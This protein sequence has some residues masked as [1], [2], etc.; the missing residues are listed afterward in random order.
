[1]SFCAGLGD[2]G[3]LCVCPRGLRFEETTVEVP[4]AYWYKSYSTSSSRVVLEY[5]LQ[6]YSSLHSI[7]P[8]A[9]T[10]THSSLLAP[11]WSQDSM[12]ARCCDRAAMRPFLF[13]GGSVSGKWVLLQKRTHLDTWHT[14]PKN[15]SQTFS[16][17]SCLRSHFHAMIFPYPYPRYTEILWRYNGD[18]DGWGILYPRFFLAHMIY[19]TSYDIPNLKISK[20]IFITLRSMD[21]ISILWVSL[22]L[23]LTLTHGEKISEEHAYR[24][25]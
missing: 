10:P 18:R 15:V 13:D 17:W 4:A 16:S 23:T 19:P 20:H 12:A 11:P 3:P 22:T 2:W 24:G 6:L 5:L 14:Q 9:Q 8:G 7:S 25:R 1:M 21:N